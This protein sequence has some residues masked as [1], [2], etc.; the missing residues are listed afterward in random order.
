M[1]IYIST[2]KNKVMCKKGKKITFYIP[3]NTYIISILENVL[4]RIL[5]WFLKQGVTM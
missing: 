3:L 1:E 4:L 5:F 2:I